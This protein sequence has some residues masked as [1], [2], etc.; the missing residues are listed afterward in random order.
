[1][2]EPCR[3]Q[4]SARLGAPGLIST[5]VFGLPALLAVALA[6]E[7]GDTQYAYV[8]PGA[9]FAFLGSF[10]TNKMRWTD[11]SAPTAM[12]LVLQ[13]RVRTFVM[14]SYFTFIKPYIRPGLV[15]LH[16]K[17]LARKKA[18]GAQPHV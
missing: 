5:I 3:A 18:P 4:P 2:I 17:Y 12:T 6:P 10:L 8:G 1:M 13:R 7:A 11:A 16:E 14:D 9:G 15:A